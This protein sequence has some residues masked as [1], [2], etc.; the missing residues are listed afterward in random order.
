MKM[1][2][3]NV[4][5][6]DLCSDDRITLVNQDLRIFFKPTN[7]IDLILRS[8]PKSSLNEII[9][10]GRSITNKVV[11]YLPTFFR[12]LLRF[13]LPNADTLPIVM[14]NNKAKTMNKITSKEMQFVFKGVLSKTKPYSIN[15]KYMSLTSSS[16]EDKLI[17]F[18]LWK[19][20]NPTL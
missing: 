1:C 6:D 14:I 10:Y 12:Q 2:W 15:S 11:R 16:M 4:N 19:I 7:K 3:R 9:K 20:K 8:F 13:D 5:I 18:Y 17:W